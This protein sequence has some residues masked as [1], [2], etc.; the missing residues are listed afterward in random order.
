MVQKWGNPEVR[1]WMKTH[2]EEVEQSQQRYNRLKEMSL[3]GLVALAQS[4]GADLTKV[5]A[6]LITAIVAVESTQ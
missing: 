6:V 3:D 4:D 5:K 2:K 1:E